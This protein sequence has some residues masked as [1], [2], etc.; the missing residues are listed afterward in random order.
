MIVIDGRLEES[1][2]VLFDV[3][4]RGLLLADG[5]FET[6]LA[7]DGRVFRRDA[8]LDRMI[9]GA[10]ALAIPIDRTRL[11][12]DLDLLLATLPTG[13]AVVRLTVTRGPGARGARRPPDA[14]RPTVLVTHAPWAKET[15]MRPLRLVTS[16]IRRNETSPTSRHK[17]L[18]Y[19]DA[20]AALAE[21]EAK[22]AD[23]ALLFNM[24]GAVACA[25][26]GNVFAVD[27][28]VILTPQP[29]DGILEGTIRAVVL[30]AARELGLR[31][32]EMSLAPLEFAMSET[33][34]LTNAVRLLAP[35]SGLDRRRYP[36]DHPT[37][38][39]LAEAIG[40]RIAAECGRD[41]R[42]G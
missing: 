41:P 23:D 28:D 20:G 4:D 5:V 27:G 22:G 40:A 42:A 17:T 29:D 7:V 36:T 39:R 30:E 18:A 14:V 24:R 6:M 26:T 19:V 35:I 31:T 9:A 8:H 25:T 11:E 37:V 2:K 21:A 10:T 15:V 1:E 32:K 38:T 13:E 12:A 33:L 16:T 34:F 3:S